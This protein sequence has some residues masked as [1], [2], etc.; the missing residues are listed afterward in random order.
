M[1][2]WFAGPCARRGIP[3][4]NLRDLLPEAQFL[5]CRDFVVAGCSADSRRVE[6][7]QV[8]VAIRGQKHDGHDHLER[9][10]ERGAVGVVVE[11]FAARAGHP[12]VVVADARSAHARIC[13]ALAGCPSQSTRVVA[14]AGTRGVSAAGLLLRS[15][16]EAG[17]LRVATIGPPE[18]CDQGPSPRIGPDTP[19][20]QALAEYLAEAVEGGG[21]V[22]LVAATSE[23]IARRQLDGITLEMALLSD[24]PSDLP[25]D[26]LRA[27]RA[28]LG[29]LARQVRPDGGVVASG[30]DL[31]LAPL[32]GTN[33]RA[34]FRTFG[35]SAALDVTGS[36][37]RMTPYGTVLRARDEEREVRVRLRLVGRANADHAL[38]AVAAAREL[39]VPWDVV[40]DGL[41]AVG[42]I[43]GHLERTETDRGTLIFVD[44]A[45][46]AADLSRALGALRDAVGPE[47]R[48]HCL[49]GAEGATTLAD[50]LA[51]ARVAEAG[52]DQVILAPANP[53]GESA[54]A[55]VGDL[56][57]GLRRP[58]QALALNDRREA[59]AAS[60]AGAGPGDIVLIAGRGRERF[61]VGPDS[62]DSWT[63]HDVIRGFVAGDQPPLQ[64]I[65]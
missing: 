2:R 53:R 62:F 44:K 17:G 5:G 13:Q 8:F 58:G 41:E 27:R 11:H 42:A 25:A 34:R 15:V 37:E 51:L 6:P 40:V 55:L 21:E 43:P 56:R 14:V 46:T 28:A 3:S 31:E 36:I 26:E 63:D 54:P 35:L 7:G 52:A 59:I 1:A 29:R 9:A 4:V 32:A 19:G 48:V 16:L 64:R 47:T 24:L 23:A 33:L 12:Q 65:A 39:G 61:Y 50:R 10:L 38:A 18:W 60:L 45:K 57:A 20:P 30:D 22:V 49:V